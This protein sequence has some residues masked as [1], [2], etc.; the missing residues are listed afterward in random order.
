M[1]KKDVPTSS[2]SVPVLYNENTHSLML[3]IT[4][5]RGLFSFFFFF[6]YA[7]N[8]R[9]C[10]S[11]K[12]CSNARYM[13]IM[14]EKRGNNC[15]LKFTQSLRYTSSKFDIAKRFCRNWLKKNLR[16]LVSQLETTSLTTMVLNFL[17]KFQ[18]VGMRCPPGIT[19]LPYFSHFM[20]ILFLQHIVLFYL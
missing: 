6:L 16:R 14:D 9:G 13:H 8:L 5:R 1:L 2:S 20:T 19:F 17:C 18:L 3:L 15:A 4:C 7:L 12:K 11:L 10:P